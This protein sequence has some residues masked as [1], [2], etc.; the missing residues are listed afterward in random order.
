MKKKLY[1]E[2]DSVTQTVLVECA[3]DMSAASIYGSCVKTNATH[4]FG[5][6]ENAIYA[7]YMRGTTGAANTDNSTCKKATAPDT[8][9]TSLKLKNG[10]C[11]YFGA[12]VIKIDINGNEGPNTNGSDR[13]KLD[14]GTDGITTDMDAAMTNGW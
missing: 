7:K 8:T 1:A 5:T 9:S 10:A 4:A 13:M 3:K 2:L 14:I 6:A 11:L 12:N